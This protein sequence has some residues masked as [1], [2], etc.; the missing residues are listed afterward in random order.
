MDKLEDIELAAI[1]KERQDMP[2]IE[3]SL[4]EL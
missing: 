4:D 2:E 1:V 3:V